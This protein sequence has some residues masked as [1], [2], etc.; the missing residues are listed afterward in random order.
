MGEIGDNRWVQEHPAVERLVRRIAADI[1]RCAVSQRPDIPDALINELLDDVVGNVRLFA[2]RQL[3]HI[4]ELVQIGLGLSAEK[5]LDRLLDMIV[6][7]A[8]RFTNADGGALYIRDD[9]REVLDFAIVQNESMGIHMGGT[10]APVTWSSVL[11]YQPD[12]T[13][14]HQNVSAHC[15]LNGSP[16]NIPDVYVAEG[17]DFQGTKE[18]DASTGYRS[19]SMLVIPMRDH[20]EEIIGVLQLINARDRDTGEVGAFPEE[21]VEMVTSLASEAAVAV[22]NMRLVRGLENLLNAFIQTIADAIDE[23]SPYTAGH[24]LRVAAMTERLAE[25]VNAAESGPFAVISFSPAEM[26]EI[27][28]AAWLHDIGKITTP[29][30]VVDKATKLETVFDRIELVRNRVE[31][32]KRDREI[33]R[34]RNLLAAGGGGTVAPEAAEVDHRDLDDYLRFLEEVNVGGESLSEESLQRI[35]K[36]AGVGLTIGGKPM[37]L[38][39][40][41]EVKNLS[42]RQGTLTED[43]RRRVGNH[44]NVSIKMLEGLPFPKKLRRVPLYAGL[45]H[46]KLDGSGYPH[47]LSGDEIPLQARIM[48]VAD[49]FEALTASDRPYKRGKRLSEAMHILEQMVHDHKLDGDVCDLLVESGLVV[50]YAQGSLSDWQT[51]DFE[52]RGKRYPVKNHQG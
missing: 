31:I 22:T 16:V 51:D 10:G 14:N 30:F 26:A 1:R 25:K 35:R 21:E 12:G 34:L 29:E 52:W 17:F 23:K 4:Y 47:G 38:L 41:D 50:E 49:I 37:P 44:V 6:R 5:Q 13:E 20:E 40:T 11:L 42:I 3:S 33:R 7:E 9:E 45:H 48:A 46:E 39:D 15:A 28:M 36:I 27:R 19:R 24:I 2:E 8:R 43:E 18:F 32:L